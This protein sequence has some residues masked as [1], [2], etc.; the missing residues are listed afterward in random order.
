L[1][2]G[3]LHSGADEYPPERC[4]R[5]IIEG[6]NKTRETDKG[7]WP[8]QI[9]DVVL[10]LAA[11]V[12]IDL[13]PDDKTAYYVEWSIGK[14]SKV[15]VGTGMVTTVL[16]DLA[17]PQDVTV[18]WDT[19]QIFVSERTGAVLQVWP[20]A[21]RR[22]PIATPGG[23][24]HQLAL[25]KEGGR[26]YL[27]TVCYDS[28]NLLCIDPDA[29]TTQ[30]IATGLGH[31]VGIVIDAAHKFAYVTEQDKDALTRVDLASGTASPIH[32]GLI[33]PFFLAWEDKDTKVIFCVQRDPANSLVRLDLGPPLTVNVIASGLAWRPSGVAPR[34]DNK[35]IYICADQEL[36][37]ISFNGGPTIKPGRP[38]FEVHS[39]HFNFDRTVAITLKNHITGNLIALPEYI[40]GKRNE[41]A[42]YVA[43]ALPHLKVV[44]RQ[45]SGFTSGA[46][47]IG[48]TGSLGGVRRK[49]VTPTFNLLGLSNPIDFELMWPLPGTVGKPDVSLNWYAHKA[50]GPAVP[51]AIGSAIHKLY[52]LCGRPTAPW[53]SELPWVAALE[54][55]CGWAD[56]AWTT[57]HAATL[58]TERYNGSGRVSYDTV[59]G[60]TVYGLSNYNFTE[61]LER[62]NGGP[63]LG[64]KVNCTDSANT[65]STL[66]NLIGCD[67]WQSRME[68]K[69][70]LNPVIAIGYN[71]WEVPF[72]SG[73]RYHE[74][75]WKGA[76]T[77]SD[78]LFDGCLKV[79]G[80]VDPTAAPRTP[81][82][83]TN[84]VFGDCTTMNYRLRLCRPGSDGCGA[85]VPQPG[86]TR[87]RRPI[88]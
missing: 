67:L 41:P 12:G 76:C 39:V 87:Q 58:I 27:Y 71:V 80:D 15:E 11:G 2:D 28:G 78:N 26:R 81:L 57:D 3:T 72:G 53:I 8:V 60:Q 74:V 50:P 34:S 23:A 31:P 51:T 70:A 1:T 35:L 85:C 54:L 33:A 52:L 9:N 83:P 6:A 44:F 64:A 24:P 46:Y 62:L 7:D 43:G 22:R 69:F 77:Q 75:A 42:A 63:G 17:Y 59:S 21:R 45:L 5:R 32:V 73:F 14:L 4:V 86:T 68:S 38:P 29:G 25:V 18:D 55:A 36:E 47:D 30:T 16:T 65:V 48:A 20:G 61:M 40:K 56:G 79:D 82:L 49:T 10:G 19:E 84:I 66:A 88:I 37:V 13:S